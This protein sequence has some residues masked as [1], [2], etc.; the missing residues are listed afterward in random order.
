MKKVSSKKSLL[1][2]EDN[3]LLTG[4]YQAAFEKEGFAILVAHDGETGLALA[5]QKKPHLILLDLLMPGKNGFEVLSEL[6]KDPATA[7]IKVVIL[8]IVE[9][10]QSQEKAKKLGATGYLIKSNLKMPEI[11]AQVKALS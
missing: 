5:R 7:G 2:I 8:T 6:K 3:P 10:A 1:L 9:D 11:V 4:L